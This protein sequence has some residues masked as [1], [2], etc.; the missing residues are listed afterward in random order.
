MKLDVNVL[1]Q[2]ISDVHVLLVLCTVKC[3]VDDL[4]C[5]V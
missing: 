2:D 3:S 4:C 1:L 5:E